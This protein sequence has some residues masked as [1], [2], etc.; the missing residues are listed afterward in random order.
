MRAIT[1]HQPWATLVAIGEKKIET[2]SWL[3]QYRGKLAIHAGRNT[4]YVNVRSR[5]YLCDEEP[6]RSILLDW[7]AWKNNTMPLGC[8]VA[9]CNL[10]EVARI[11]LAISFPAC[12]AYWHNKREWRLSAQ[13]RA[14]GDYSVG[15]YMWLLD[16]VQIL[17]EP[18]PAKGSMGFWEWS[19]E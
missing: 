6:F 14:F 5:D 1:L 17:P 11:N 10:V 18:I 3:T 19:G 8:I 12:R 7:M 16:N 9:T 15:R 2:R 4:K 13:E